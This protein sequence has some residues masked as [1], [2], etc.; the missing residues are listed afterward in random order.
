[1]LKFFDAEAQLLVEGVKAQVSAVQ[2]HPARACGRWRCV[3]VAAVQLGIITMPHA[4][5]MTARPAS[6]R[7]S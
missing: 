6:A 5:S 3:A 4:W 1:M 7:R 2:K